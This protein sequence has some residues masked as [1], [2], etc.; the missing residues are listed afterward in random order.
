MTTVPSSIQTS[1]HTRSNSFPSRSHPLTSEVD[2]HLSRLASSDSASTS[3]S[4]NQ[5][6]SRVQDLHDCIEKMLQLP[7][8]QQ[9]LSQEQQRECVD[10]LLNGSLKL[11]DVCATAKDA[12]LQ[13]KECT[14]ELQSVLRRKR[15]VTKGFVNEVRKYLTS[16]KVA[17]KSILKALQNLKHKENKQSTV[18]TETGSIVS[19]LREVQA[20]TLNVVQS[21]LA[22]TFGPEKESQMIRWSMV[23]KLLH[24]K[25]VS[26]EGEEQIN[27]M[28]IVDASLQSLA[29]S[30]S[31]M[32]QI[33]KVQNELKLSESCIQD[34]EEGLEGLFR[35]LIKVRVNIL[36]TL[37]H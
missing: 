3:S 10:E 37:N 35:G 6:L 13:V 20:V 7:F 12:L 33:E 18:V 9:I 4:L 21:L 19:L 31:D 25:R 22:F 1:Y 11:L 8:S 5:K 32:K 17:K 27:E 30:K 34:F 16:K 2:E 28:E 29:T 14:L 24:P 15:G 23:A 26:S 36:N